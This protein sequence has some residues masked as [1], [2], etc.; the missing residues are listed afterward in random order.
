MA[1]VQCKECDRS[2]SDQADACPHC[3]FPVHLDV[4]KAQHSSS[5][6]RVWPTVL[7]IVAGVVFILGVGFVGAVSQLGRTID[8]SLASDPTAAPEANQSSTTIL[9]PTTIPVPIP[10]AAVEWAEGLVAYLTS[11]IRAAGWGARW[12]GAVCARGRPIPRGCVG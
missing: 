5:R 8:E 12:H 9:P 7:A 2:I 6:G 11:E 4:D 3:G 10:D 1:L